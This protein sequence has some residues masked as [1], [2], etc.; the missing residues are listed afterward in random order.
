MLKAGPFEFTRSS[1][2]AIRRARAPGHVSR[3][4]CHERRPYDAFDE[5]MGCKGLKYMLNMT[6][7]I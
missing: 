7:C 4:S 6:G 3:I 5:F 1:S 2:S